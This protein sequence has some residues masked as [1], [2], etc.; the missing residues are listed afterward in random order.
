MAAVWQ[1]PPLTVHLLVILLLVLVLLLLWNLGSPWALMA[2]PL[3]LIGRGSAIR[4]I[5]WLVTV[6]ASIS[7]TAAWLGGPQLRSR[8]VITWLVAALVAAIAFPGSIAAI[9]RAM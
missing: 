6:A 1:H 2:E 3:W 8:I 9:V 7:I 4:A 5:L